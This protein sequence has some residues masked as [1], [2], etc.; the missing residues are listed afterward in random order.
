MKLRVAGHALCLLL[1]LPCA[2]ARAGQ[3]TDALRGFF[4]GLQTLQADFDQQVVDEAGRLQQS[5][6]GHMWIMRP[7]R[8][9]WDYEQP[10]H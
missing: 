8:F 2:S 3:P 4:D 1:V 6:Q 5:S 7:G 9:R 10:Y